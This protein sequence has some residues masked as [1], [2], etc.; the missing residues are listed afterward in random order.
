MENRKPARARNHALTQNGQQVYFYV[1]L[2]DEIDIICE[3]LDSSMTVRGNSQ[4]SSIVSQE[5]QSY[6]SGQ[7]SAADVAAVI[8]N[9]VSVYLAEQE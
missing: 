8:Q 5:A 6:F 1:P 9:R 3:L 2:P 7:K 4:I